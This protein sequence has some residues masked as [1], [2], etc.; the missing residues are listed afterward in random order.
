MQATSK[1]F[2]TRVRGK[3]GKGAARCFAKGLHNP[4]TR[5]HDWQASEEI[6]N[7][8]TNFC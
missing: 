7:N 3:D 6:C 2:D 8:E 1:V 4:S 5:F